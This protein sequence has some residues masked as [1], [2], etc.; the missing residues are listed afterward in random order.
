MRELADNGDDGHW[1]Y[2]RDPGVTFVEILI[3][4]VL[5][6]TVVLGVLAATATL[7]R[8]SKTSED[9]ARVET[10]LVSAAERIERADRATF[11]CDLSPLVVAAMRAEFGIDETEARANLTIGQQWYQKEHDEWIGEGNSL[12]HPNGQACPVDAANQPEFQQGLVQKVV[13]EMTSPE[14]GVTRTLEVVKSD[15]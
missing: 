15:A 13:I 1:P 4:I 10:A 6:G 8:A 12:W 14:S 2:Q 5:M 7:L 9:A 3:T 11:D